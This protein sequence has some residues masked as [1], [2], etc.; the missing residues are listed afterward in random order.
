MGAAEE[1]RPLHAQDPPLTNA[2]RQE[3]AGTPTATPA[4]TPDGVFPS[5]QGFVSEMP[6]A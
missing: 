1:G 5:K 4:L 3:G 6:S 2:H